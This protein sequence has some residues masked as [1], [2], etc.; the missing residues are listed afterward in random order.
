MSVNDKDN[1][2]VQQNEHIKEFLRFGLCQIIHD[3][4]QK[5]WYANHKG[6][7]PYLMDKGKFW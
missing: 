4:S 6:Y 3:K 2:T 7:P 5:D 1:Y